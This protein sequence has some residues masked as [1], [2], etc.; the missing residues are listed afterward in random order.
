MP[1]IAQPIACPKCRAVLGPEF[2]NQPAWGTCPSCEAKLRVEIF[3]ALFR[4]EKIVAGE[5][6]Q[7]P[8]EASC[9][10]HPEKKAAVVCDA[11]GRFLCSLCEVD[12]DGRTFAP[13]ASKPAGKKAKSPSWNARERAT[14]ISPWRWPCC[15]CYFLLDGYLRAGGLVLCHLA[16]EIAWQHCPEPAAAD[17]DHG[18][19]HSPPLRSP[20]GWRS[21]PGSSSAN[22]PCPMPLQSSTPAC[23][24]AA[25][26][27]KGASIITVARITC[28]L[29]LGDDHLFQVESAGGYSETYKRFYFRDIQAIYLRKT[30]S[31]QTV[32]FVLGTVTGLFLLWTLSV[33]NI[34]GVVTLGIITGVFGFFLLLNLLHGSTC[35]CH[36]QSAVHLEELPSL[37][38]RRNAEKVLSRL[39]PLIDSAQGSISAE[40]VAPQYAAPARAGQ[41]RGVCARPGF[42]CGRRR[43]VNVYRGRWHQ[44]LFIA[45]LAEALGNTLN[46]FLPCMPI[47][48]SEHI[49]R[50][51]AGGWP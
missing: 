25:L 46:I 32:N 28:R 16:L 50:G 19:R 7:A 31:W 42:A 49:R 29:W 30:N 3:P 14:T 9:F 22:D 2:F 34:P 11:C 17:P 27:R 38:R 10:Y 36:L 43:Q 40:K 44:I 5:A 37:R 21:S 4:E 18:H 23:P 20:G 13:R 8:G 24:A 39:K 48:L 6:I 15:R 35:E 1:A 12:F 41:R 26:S 33:K 47:A 51:R 45:L